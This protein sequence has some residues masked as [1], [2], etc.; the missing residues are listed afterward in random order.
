MIPKAMTTRSPA[1]PQLGYRSV[2]WLFLLIAAVAL[3]VSDLAVSALNPWA[4]MR[5][6]AAGLIRPDFFSIE[7]MSV[8]WTVAFAVLGVAIGA[9][10]GFLLAL[11][12]ARLR[13]VR[14]LCAFLRS[15]HEMFWAL[16]LIQI[17]GLS[18]TTG[19]LA[20]AIPYSG[21]FAKV[22]A[23]MIEE[24]DLSA[25][26]V[27]PAGTS[28][29]ARFAYAR[30]PELAPQFWTY[31]LYRLE[32]GMR[33]T[34]VLGFIGLPTIGFHLDSF[35]KQGHY[36]EAAALL[37]AFYVL[38]GTRRLW[39]RPSTVPFLII[40]S[41]LVLPETIGGG[42]ALANL[43][44]FLTHDI[45]PTPL[46]N[47]DLLAAATWENFSAWLWPIITK[48]AVPGVIQTLVLSQ[49]ALVAMGL[50]A[51]ILFPFICRRFAGRLG[52]PLGRVAL[53]VVRSTPEYMLVYV[54]LQLLG[55]S[56]LPAIIALSLHNGAI[57]G[58]LMGRH[59]DVLEYRRDAPSGVNLYCYETVPR[60]Y[61]QFLA[62]A[63]YRWEIIL[64]ESAI[65]GI[66][67][68]A[69]LGY[70]IDAAISEF[71]LDVAVVLILVTALLSMA[72][73]AF[74][75]GLRRRLRIDTMPTRLSEAPSEPAMGRL[76]GAE[77]PA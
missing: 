56:M 57:V 5:R 48:Q 31:T 12:F 22:F 70:Y 73:D 27:L 4:E 23:E 50:I 10:T 76:V 69:T 36:R 75:R 8:V 64:R 7:M 14:L 54:L 29:I 37:F 11:V 15:V 74:S 46:R 34:L 35:F 39:A 16:L 66:L 62:Y 33:S 20:V 77:R 49:V 24:A 53:V 25:E 28:T 68:V 63:L 3:V 40:A 60:L 72:V 61:G 19:I 17:A 44:R 26:R 21:I 65:F 9:S 47:A 6:L 59:A 67:G 51:L 38:I 41:V 42:S 1:L 45:I 43:T 58:Y 32:C 55:P 2:S 71:R 30:I 52:Q 13:A 18:A